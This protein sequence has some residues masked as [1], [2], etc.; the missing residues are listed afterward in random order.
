[1]AATSFDLS[2]VQR[3][4]QLG[5]N[6]VV[7]PYDCADEDG[8]RQKARSVIRWTLVT[9]RAAKARATATAR[10]AAA[11][12]TSTGCPLGDGGAGDVDVVLHV[13]S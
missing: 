10:V 8:P 4:D 2:A 1:M 11:V 12:A 7:P 5:L 3:N 6:F 9:E 13:S